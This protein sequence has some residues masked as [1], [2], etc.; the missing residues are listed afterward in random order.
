MGLLEVQVH[1]LQPA[2]VTEEELNH[3]LAEYDDQG[4]ILSGIQWLVRACCR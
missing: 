3:C 1:P 2:Y 4:L